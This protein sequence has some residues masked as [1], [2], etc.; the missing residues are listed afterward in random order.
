MGIMGVPGDSTYNIYNQP[1]GAAS[2]YFSGGKRISSEGATFKRI[3]KSTHA[4]LGSKLIDVP[5]SENFAD[6]YDGQLTFF[7]TFERDTTGAVLAAGEV[8]VGNS[9]ASCSYLIETP[10]HRKPLFGSGELF[11]LDLNIYHD[12]LDFNQENFLPDI[13]VYKLKTSLGTVGTFG[14]ARVD[15][16]GDAN[17]M[18]GSNSFRSVPSIVETFNGL[19]P[20][21]VTSGT[22]TSQSITALNN[23]GDNA[24]AGGTLYMTLDDA[25]EI[26]EG[27][28]GGTV[29][30]DYST[31]PRTKS[32][33]AFRKRYAQNTTYNGEYILHLYQFL[34][35]MGGHHYMTN[36][37]NSKWK[38]DPSWRRYSWDYAYAVHHGR[39]D[40]FI[41]Q[42]FFTK[43]GG[44]LVQTETA[45]EEII[46]NHLSTE[47]SIFKATAK[48]SDDKEGVEDIIK[49][50]TYT[51]SYFSNSDAPP[52]GAAW[53]QDLFWSKTFNPTDKTFNGTKQKFQTSMAWLRLPKPLRNSRLHQTAK[54]DDDDYQG[55]SMEVDIKFSIIG[56]NKY[57]RNNP[58]SE[59]TSND[60]KWGHNLLRSFI[61]MAAT[62]P[63]NSDEGETLSNYLYGLT[64][65][66]DWLN[67]GHN[68]VL[69]AD[70]DGVGSSATRNN[71]FNGVAFIRYANETNSE[72][73]DGNIWIYG[74]GSGSSR[75][76]YWGADITHQLPYLARSGYYGTIGGPD[77]PIESA[78]MYSGNAIE[79][80]EY[81]TLKAI[82]NYR[83]SAG[84]GD[85]SW[86]LL[87]AENKVIAHRKQR[88]SG[89][90]YS[91]GP[92]LSNDTVGFPSYLSFW[93]NNAPVGVGTGYGDHTMELIEGGDYGGDIPLYNIK[94][95]DSQVSVVI[96]T[97][98]ISGFEGELS[99]ASIVTKNLQPKALHIDAST[100][101]SFV[102]T[103]A[104]FTYEEAMPSHIDDEDDIEKKP[105]PCYLTWGTKSNILTAADDGG[106]K[107]NNIFLGGF[108]TSLTEYNTAPTFAQSGNTTLSDINLIIPDETGQLGMWNVL[109]RSGNVDVD[110]HHN[111]ALTLGSGDNYIDTFTKKGFFTIN[112]QTVPD[113]DTQ[114]SRENPAFSTKII[115]IDGP[116]ARGKLKVVNPAAL[117][118]NNDEEYIIYRAG[119]TYG[120][121]NIRSGL[122][123]RKTIDLETGDIELEGA[124]AASLHLA[125]DG[126]SVLIDDAYLHELYISPKRFWFTIEI[127]NKDA[128]T[129]E[130]LPAK[131]YDYS[132]IQQGTAPGSTVKGMTWN[133]RLYSDSAGNSNRWNMDK[134]GGLVETS[135][136]F[137]YG[138]RKEDG[139]TV[140]FEESAGY[141]QKYVP[142]SGFNIVSLD[143]Y[144]STESGRLAKPDE[145]INLYIEGSPESKGSCA[146]RTLEYGSAAYFPYFTFYY[147]DERP[148]IDSF[149]VKPNES[150]PFYPTF[151]WETQD[152]DLWYGFLLLSNQEIKHQYDGAVAH[153]PLN[154]T[155]VTATGDVKLYKY[156]GTDSGEPVGNDGGGEGDNLTTVEGLA[157]NAFMGDGSTTSYLTWNDERYT[158]PSTQF[159]LVAHFTCNSVSATA[160]IV[161]KLNEFEIYT[162]TSGNINATL[163]PNGGTAVA[164]KSTTLVST[165]GETPTN[166]I[167]TLDN[168]LGTANVKLFING[169]LEDQSG[170]VTAA[171]SVNNWKY[172]QVLNDDSSV[173]TIGKRSGGGNYHNGTIEE[174]VLYN[175]V[176]YPVVPQTG[177]LNI[178]KPMQEFTISAI[179][180]GISNVGRLF[181]KDYHNIR[182]TLSNDVTSSSMVSYRKSGLGLKTDVA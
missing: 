6:V 50:N 158:Q 138:A 155:V 76:N 59:G 136:D 179:A 42:C 84:D 27:N 32:K 149:S 128:S 123:I 17:V 124:S 100:E 150:D 80:G 97:I 130:N 21:D 165:D 79:T 121:S 182:G 132:L 67:Y 92:L 55:D 64:S 173:L 16:S 178:Y 70:A 86:V 94:T 46:K 162:D 89:N 53:K 177:T 25:W 45:E 20:I 134:V 120:T 126:S 116:V 7:S 43:G 175:K 111:D 31:S 12:N 90:T 47:N 172:G 85:I 13:E 23:Y 15:S 171:G 101:S 141:I 22:V 38:Y 139:D 129:N 60:N 113:P 99:N 65:D 153:I 164:L 54:V 75:T 166:V 115:K 66:D 33:G 147:F 4:L 140:D 181:V 160:Y 127:Y 133:E 137:G 10:V 112:F 56:M 176:I 119:Q 98:S 69:L 144:I 1:V 152:E 109:G 96:D 29:S 36:K 41:K 74:S 145:K 87:D 146:I 142:I 151:E 71:N 131:T 62:R 19:D 169:K 39:E 103:D 104:A 18:C 28:Y 82:F 148:S 9:P 125:D 5:V 105:I 63:P 170:V 156:D 114:T 174:V 102:N 77:T 161:S 26:V 108:N 81:Y 110:P 95:H 143:G 3:L 78:R 37:G 48:T 34:G 159:S 154:E 24:Q 57:H 83:Q 8:A 61:V 52:S 163:K 157:G 91:S 88:H 107:T 122:S 35:S 93:V 58:K 180:S 40:E 117:L 167:L 51:R 30:S 106:S 68:P 135:I 14:A 72:P 168:T 49:Y 2:K 44:G 118:G 73:D 11:G